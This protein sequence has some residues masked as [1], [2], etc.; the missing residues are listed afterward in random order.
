MW[1]FFHTRDRGLRPTGS[2]SLLLNLSSLIRKPPANQAVVSATC[3]A[4]TPFRGIGESYMAQAAS[5]TDLGSKRPKEV[6]K[7]R[8]NSYGPRSRSGLCW[9]PPLDQTGS[10]F[11]SNP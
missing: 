7:R 2:D 11:S 8:G 3:T 10:S 1:Y 5:L 4:H 6:E 9:G